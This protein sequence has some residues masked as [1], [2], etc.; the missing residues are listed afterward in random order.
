MRRET[1]QDRSRE[2]LSSRI[3]DFQQTINCK[4]LILDLRWM[5]QKM[6]LFFDLIIDIR[7]E[8]ARTGH[9]AL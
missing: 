8:L 5:E 6:F 3:K 4:R 1:E 2:L 9:I 7:H